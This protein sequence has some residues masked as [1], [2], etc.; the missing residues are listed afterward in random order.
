M[1]FLYF[2]KNKRCNF[3]REKQLNYSDLEDSLSSKSVGSDESLDLRSLL[4]FLTGFGFEFSSNDGLLD[5][6]NV[7]FF[8]VETE[9]FS[10]SVQ[11]FGTQSSGN[12]DIGQSFN[13]GFSLF[14]QDEVKGTNIGTNDASS[15]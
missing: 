15:N 3:K 13:G 4:S 9:K 10:D 6:R 1:L 8:L 11:S 12:L 2:L 5:E 7:V 14:N